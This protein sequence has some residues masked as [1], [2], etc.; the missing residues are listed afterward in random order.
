V[1]NLPVPRFPFTRKVVSSEQS[2]ERREREAEMREWS[3]EK[4][5]EGA[6]SGEGDGDEERWARRARG[7]EGSDSKYAPT[8]G[9]LALSSPAW[10]IRVTSGSTKTPSSPVLALSSMSC[11]VPCPAFEVGIDEEEEP[12]GPG[13][14]EESER[15]SYSTLVITKKTRPVG[16]GEVGAKD[17]HDVSRQLFYQ[18]VW[19]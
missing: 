11:V 9:I 2:R 4:G 10:T 3:L 8:S 5:D 18:S 12:E 17:L 1:V 19:R 13:S 15:T 7:D 16:G 14:E 6:R